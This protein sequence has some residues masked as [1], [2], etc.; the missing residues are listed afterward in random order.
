MSGDCRP[1][2]SRAGGGR[3]KPG[4]LALGVYSI[5]IGIGAGKVLLQKDGHTVN[6]FVD[7]QFTPFH[8]GFGQPQVQVFAGVNF[9]FPLKK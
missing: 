8:Y 4:P 5:P 3:P 1:V 2:S 6:I 9:Q 7:P